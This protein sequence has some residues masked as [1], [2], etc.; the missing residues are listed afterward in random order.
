MSRNRLILIVYLLLGSAVSVKA[1]VQG[2]SRTPI[3]QSA[4]PIVFEPAAPQQ[5]SLIAIIGRVAGGTVEFQPSAMAIHSVRKESNS[6]GIS[7]DG[8]L[9]TVPKGADLEQ[10]QTNYLLGNDPARWRTHVSNYTKVVYSNLYPGIDAVFYG[11]G[12]HLEHDFIVKPGADYRQI[13]MR[14][15]G[16]RVH[17]NKDGSLIM[18][19]AGDSLR[20]DAPAIYQNEDGKR[21]R[22]NGAFRLLPNGDVSFTVDSYNPHFDLVIDPVLIF[23]TYLSPLGSDGNGIATDANGNSYVTGYATLGY[24]VTT[25][26]FSGCATCTTNNVVTFVSKL[27]ADGSK[28][29][30]STVL[31]GNSFAQPTGIAVDA[32]GDA[33]V[34]GWTGASDFPTKSGQ[35]ILPQMNNYVGFLFSLAPDGASLNYGTLLGPSPTAPVESMTY[36]TAVAVDDSGNAYVT[37]ETGEGFFISSGALNQE[38]K[39]DTFYNSFNIYLAKFNPTGTLLYSAVLGTA[40]PQNGGGGPIGASAIAVDATGN[41]YVTGQAGTLWPITSGAYLSQIA[42]P[43]PYATPFVMKVAPD[44]KSVIYSTYLDYAYVM[45]GISIVASGDVFVTGNGAD[46][47]YPTTSNAYESN[48]GNSTSFL[49]ELNASGSA[50]VYSTMVCGGPCTVNG[51]ALDTNGNI[52]LA[53]QTSNAGF[54]LLLPLQSTFPM[55]QLSSGPASALAEFDPTGQTLKFSTF[56]GGIAPGYASSVATDASH[57]VHVSGAAQYGM[58]TTTGAYAGSVPAPGQGLTTST[59][60]YVAVADPTV[61]SPGLCVAPNTGLTFGGV[62]LG[63][64]ADAKL[65]IT[66]CGGNPL[67]VSAASTTSND[68][69]IPASENGCIGT[70]PIG[71]SCTLGVQFTPSVAGAESS[72]LTVDSNSPIPVQLNLSGAGIT[73]PIMSLSASS[74]TFGPQLV[75]TESASQTITITN[76][77]NAALNGIFFGMTL[78]LEPIFPLTTTCGPTVSPGASCT[79]S[80]AFKPATTGTTAT[81]MVVGN[82]SGLPFQQVDLSGT[83]PQSPFL[84]GTQTGGSMTSTV[85][86]G[87][88]ATYALKITPAGGYSG[89]VSLACSSLPANASCTFVSSTLALSGGAAANFTLSILTESTQTGSVLGTAG[90]G[91]ALAGFLFFF[92]LKRKRDRVAALICFGAL[93]LI[94]SISACGGGSSGAST[95]QAAK[96]APGTYAVKVVASDVSGNQVTQSITLIVQ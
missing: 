32:N 3:A 22:R 7:F 71:Q 8:A 50:L 29:I 39:S 83:S 25:G 43:M 45:S 1:Q 14:F 26:A 70:L 96:V 48:N 13:H 6:F 49:T 81:T 12:N 35:P 80:V 11:N 79:F 20:V 88:T 52:W 59:Y 93:L 58:Y 47:T 28:L 10:S 92:P 46:P 4:L 64:T 57:R 60:A 9:P 36:A 65:T 15:S 21:R 27:S 34:S 95:P 90:L 75:G 84:V 61:P 78:D 76:T 56:L 82:N 38:A 77:G 31:G 42:G 69:S 74:L 18:T 67:S 55:G 72:I 16:S 62:P 33:I 66:S 44:A 51:M 19:A 2:I 30:Y 87:N 54:P 63:A 40:D 41:A 89:N 73:A 86:A 23:S 5:D 68:F 85:A 37:G 17:L 91:A 94:T 53:A 24:P